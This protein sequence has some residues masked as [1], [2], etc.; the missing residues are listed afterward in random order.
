VTLPATFSI[1][2]TAVGF[3]GA[4]LTLGLSSAPGWRALRWFALCAAFAALYCFADAP[5]TLDVGVSTHILAS[6]CGLCFGGLHA[7]AWVAFTAAHENR[8]LSRVEAVWVAIGVVGSFVALVPGV[9]VEN[10][11]VARPVPLLGLDY[12]DSP[13]TRLGA[14][15]IVFFVG[16]VALMFVRAIRRRIAGDAE[17]TAHAIALGAMVLG[18]L[19]DG[20]ANA[21]IL[22]TP[23][24]LDASLL[25]LVT[26]VGGSITSR[27]VASAR[28]LE[29]SSRQLEDAREQLIERERLAALGELSAMVAHEVRNPLAVVFNATA[30]LRRATPGSPD[31]GALVTIVQEEAERLRDIVSDLL[32]FARP[33]PPVLAS[34]AF[35]EVVRSGVEAARTMHGAAETSVVVEANEE[36]GRVTCD[37]RL[38]RQAVVNLVSNALQATGRRGPVVVTI[39]ENRGRIAVRVTDDGDGVPDELRERIFTPFFSTRPKG[40]GLGLNVVRRCAEAHGGELVLESSGGRGASFELQLPRGEPI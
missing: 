34:V 29:A 10:A 33:R 13:P 21:G 1:T 16:S 36:V 26:A 6:R 18:G 28:A 25:V 22:T 12:V 11:V 32:E 3:L 31:H 8:V 35:E 24:L 39:F 5:T 37:D 30:G 4:L 23:Y 9:F 17:M 19:H 20:L 38:L 27:F 2:A 14:V 40:T 15:A 7:V